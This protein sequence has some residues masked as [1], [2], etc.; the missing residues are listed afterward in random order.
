MQ[1]NEGMA[2]RRASTL[3]MTEDDE[4]KQRNSE[5]GFQPSPQFYNALSNI[6]TSN[7]ATE[8]PEDMHLHPTIS[9]EMALSPGGPGP[10]PFEDPRYIKRSTLR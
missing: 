9:P 6:S 7:F 2:L 3:L 10:S 1:A 5:A 8:S 4:E